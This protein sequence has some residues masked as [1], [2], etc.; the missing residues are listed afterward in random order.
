VRDFLREVD[1]KQLSPPLAAIK[2]LNRV[3]TDR[4]GLLDLNQADLKIS[5]S[6]DLLLRGIK[7]YDAVLRAAAARG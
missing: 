7:L 1:I 4:D 2:K 3:E 6:P 5:V